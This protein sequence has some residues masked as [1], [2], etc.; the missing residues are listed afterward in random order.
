MDENSNAAAPGT[1]L[2]P[3]W[4]TEKTNLESM[5]GDRSS[6]YW[7]GDANGTSA[8]QFQSR[9]RD[10][11]RAEQLGQDAPVGPGF[12]VDRDMPMHVGAYDIASIPGANH[13]DAADRAMLD[14]FLPYAYDGGLGQEKVKFAAGLALTD[15]DLSE[16]KFR[17]LAEGAGW[18]DAHIA[19][20]IQWYRDACAA[21]DRPHHGVSREAIAQ[22][23][24][25][26]ESL[27]WI[28]GQPN[29]AYYSGPLESE[30]RAL[31]AAELGA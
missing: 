31:L 3:V 23:K 6:P 14:S 29:P 18:S 24:A 13:M 30:Y 5:M 8:G 16:G 25:E 7:V 20:C 10:L 19:V 11:L 26:I 15:P 4:Q 1:S 27:M 21:R 9:Y 12:E 28:D 22:R 17:L 2:A